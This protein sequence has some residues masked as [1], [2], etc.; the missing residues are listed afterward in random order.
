MLVTLNKIGAEQASPTTDTI[1]KTNILMDYAA[2]QPDAI[3]RFHAS[4]MCLHIDIDAAY[5]V[6]P[7]ARSCAVGHYY[8]SNNP[9]PPHIRPTP[10]PN[11]PILTKCQTIRTVMA[12]A[13]EA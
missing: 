3:V 9:S 10:T 5:I 7:K 11:G 6:Q 1:N 13:A 8:L 12:S 4:N 2:T